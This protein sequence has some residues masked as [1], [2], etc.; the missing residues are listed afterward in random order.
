MVACQNETQVFEQEPVERRQAFFE[1]FQAALIAPGKGWIMQY[2]PTGGESAGHN[3]FMN[4]NATY[5]VTMGAS[6]AFTSNVY[7]E[8]VSRYGLT[9]EGAPVL[10]FTTYNAVLHS[11]SDPDLNEAAGDFEFIIADFTTDFIRLK[12]KRHNADVCLTRLDDTDGEEYIR[13]AEATKNALF[14]LRSPALRLRVGDRAYTFGEGHTSVFKIREE[15]AD[16]VRNMAYIALPDGFRLYAP[17]EAG[18]AKVQ[19]FRWNDDRSLLICSDAGVNAAIG[20]SVDDATAFFLSSLEM[21]SS[22]SWN[23]QPAAL[24]GVFA[25]AYARINASYQTQNQAFDGFVLTYKP[26]IQ[27]LALSFKGRNAATP[28]EG[29]I[30][31]NLALEAGFADRVR[32]TDRNAADANGQRFLNNYDGARDFLSA[33]CAGSYTVT[34]ESPLQL[35]KFKFASDLNPDDRF[36]LTLY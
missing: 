21:N 6:H 19:T 20:S 8:H 2:F 4:F 18:D 23:V 27:G 31:I 17:F 13:R 22:Y 7:A 28:H 30:G 29:A 14:A 15:G 35:S 9:V 1:R 3:L 5:E 26:G 16:S 10:H 24:H 11:F 25:D 33:L 12:G 32:F 34:V 36:E